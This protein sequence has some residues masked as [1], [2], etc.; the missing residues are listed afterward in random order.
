MPALYGDWVR[1]ERE[2]RTNAQ[3]AQSS[4][5]TDLLTPAS[6]PASTGGSSVKTVKTHTGT[7]LCLSCMTELDLVDE[8]H[9]KCDDCGGPLLQGTL[10]DLCDEE[11]DSEDD[12]A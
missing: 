8:T 11:G 1:K 2:R 3:G 4:A 10:E 9:L 7:Y 12:P 5:T 6:F